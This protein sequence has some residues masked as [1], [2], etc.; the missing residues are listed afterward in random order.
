MTNDIFIIT[1]ATHDE[2]FFEFIKKHPDITILG[3]GT[4]W[5]GWYTRMKEI[6]QFCKTV[7]KNDIVC[8]ID[9]FDT[10]LNHCTSLKEEVKEKFIQS[11]VDIIFSKNRDLTF[12]KKYHFKKFFG[13]CFNNFIN[14]GMYV[15]RAGALIHFW[16]NIKKDDDDQRYANNMCKVTDLR[17]KT[18]NN[19]NL[20]FNYDKNVKYYIKNRRLYIHDINTSPCFIQGPARI[21]INNILKSLD[22]PIKN[23]QNRDLSRKQKLRLFWIYNIQYF[24]LEFLFIYILFII[25]IVLLRKI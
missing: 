6:I 19:Y 9:G 11:N 3:Y 23:T 4:K 16:K 1:Y 12:I 13:H 24:F 14:A 8:V 15:G 21:N 2:G 10:I 5:K 7:D 25:I 17:V 22:Y 18:D 20:F